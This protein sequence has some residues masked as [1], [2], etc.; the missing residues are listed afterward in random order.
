[1]KILKKTA[2]KLNKLDSK[3][4]QLYKNIFLS[5]GIKGLALIVSLL[6]LPAYINYFSDELIL[7]V[8]FTAISMLS[9]ILT[10][11]LGV[12]NGLRNYLVKPL[13]EKDTIEIKKNV[14]SAY[15][16]VG[17]ISVV[18]IIAS[19]V[20][21][22][23]INWNVVFNVSKEKI[24][25]DT[26]IFMVTVLMIGILIQFWL[27]LVISI[28]YALQKSAM[29]GLL[30]LIS[31]SLM[32]FFALTINAESLEESIRILSVVY[33]VTVNLPYLIATILI[34]TTTLKESKPSFKYFRKKYA[35][36]II[37]LGG[38]FFY[39]QILTMIMF[40][41]NEFLISWLIDP[42]DVVAF[43]V[44]NKLFSIL[45]TFFNL[46]ITPVWSAVTEAMVKKDIQWI[47]NLY[48]KLNIILLCLIP[49]QIIL[50][51]VIPSVV[52]IWLDIENLEINT[53][54]GIIFAIYNFLFMKVTIDTSIIA[55][56]GD[57]KI[58]A[59]AYT[60]TV[61]IKLILSIYI[62]QYTGTW[63]SIIVAN[64]IGLLPY[65]LIE[66]IDIRLKLKK[67]S[68]SEVIDV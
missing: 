24:S 66:Y 10:F 60:C 2:M 16:S 68:R 38:I 62:V 43:Q 19:L 6:T 52:D 40:N 30:V 61:V 46:A 23:Y 13:I 55:G 58:Q 51:L 64:I 14:S 54:Y 57:L 8:W 29:T 11:D 47:K 18:L 15:L 53:T 50:V 4:L 39:L 36:R 20:T 33:A 37:K 21:V 49:F 28:F 48:R 41:T 59:I 5:F 31:N 35:L 63:I 17:L 32:L 65:I 67:L 12:G 44:Y 7:G 34:F 27:K 9:W 56:L 26:L 3:S 45:S 42:K 1:M 25:I 22:P